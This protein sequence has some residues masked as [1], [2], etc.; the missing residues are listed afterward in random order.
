MNIFC[1]ILSFL[2]LFKIFLCQD[3]GIKIAI[4]EKI[5]KSIIHYFSDDINRQIKYIWIGDIDNIKE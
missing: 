5:I 3:G 2:I 1:I 4:N